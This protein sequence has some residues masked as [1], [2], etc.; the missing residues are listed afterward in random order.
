MPVMDFYRLDGDLIAENWLPMD[1]PFVAH[2]MGHDLF[3]RLDHYRGRSAT[4]L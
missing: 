4:T 2:Q 1:V 3:A